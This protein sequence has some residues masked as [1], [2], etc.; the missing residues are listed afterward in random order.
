MGILTFFVLIFMALFLW[1]STVSAHE[2]GWSLSNGYLGKTM[3]A[4]ENEG[5][6]I[7]FGL[8]FGGEEGEGLAGIAITLL[9]IS[10]AFPVLRRGTILSR[11]YVSDEDFSELKR[12]IQ[13]FYK[14][15]RKPLF[16]VHVIANGGVIT[17][18]LLH[19]LTVEME[20]NFRVTTGMLALGTLLILS[21]SGLI[22]WLRMR[23][24][25]EFK[26]ARKAVRWFHSQWIL[27]GFILL[28]LF[29]HV[30]LGELGGD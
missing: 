25:W 21:V 29:L 8:G 16:Y 12:S 10:F 2:T 20:N 30:G 27:T 19:A 11:R 4:G 23:P 3:E 28:F 24:L 6:R 1:V 7:F 9:L 14:A 15:L 26:E 17:F 13:E 5:G 18:G 22:M